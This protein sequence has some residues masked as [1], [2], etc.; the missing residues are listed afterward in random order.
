[1]DFIYLALLGL[2]F[3]LTAVLAVGCA[4]LDRKRSGGRP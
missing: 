4:R 3:A 1:M 2:F